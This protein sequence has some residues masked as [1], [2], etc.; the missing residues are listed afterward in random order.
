LSP[1]SFLCFP[2]LSLVHRNI[3]SERIGG[4][5]F[6]AIECLRQEMWRFLCR[7]GSSQGNF[8]KALI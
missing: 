7:Y 2:D 3:W 4:C 1:S 8:L 5:I 6:S